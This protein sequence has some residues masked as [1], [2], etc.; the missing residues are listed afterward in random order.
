MSLAFRIEQVAETDSTNEACRLR[1]LAGEPAGLVIRS[2]RQ[3]AGR[4]RRGRSWSSPPGNLY[5]SL[6][7]R[8][9]RPVAEAAALGFAAVIAVGDAV[10]ALLS[11]SA[12]VRH[13]WPNDLLVNGRKV[14]GVLLE[15][16]AGAGGRPDFLVLGIGVNLT[17]HP[18]DT[19]YP[20]TDL[21]AE[22]AGL[23]VPQ[24]L[25]ERLL[26]A[27]GPL[28]ELW[29]AAG[30]GALLPVWRRRAAGWGERIEVR[31]EH[32]TVSGI[33]KDLGADGTLLLA[34][35][36]GSERRISAGDVYFPHPG[37]G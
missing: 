30:F 13:K 15:T 34:L 37:R 22:G 1:A 17:G 6:L 19:P 29:E 26:A 2:D 23:I 10:E 3:S 25:L 11:P 14:S 35:P 31:L 20:A 16:Q 28:Y 33:F 24:S 21:K 36:D 32:E 8:P 7:L 12:A 27:F 9:R 18:A 5:A 4:G